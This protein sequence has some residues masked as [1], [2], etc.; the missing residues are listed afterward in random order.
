MR[1]SILTGMKTLEAPKVSDS[2]LPEVTSDVLRLFFTLV[3]RISRCYL[4]SFFD[5]SGTILDRYT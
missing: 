2:S 4:L 3:T 5:E 1:I